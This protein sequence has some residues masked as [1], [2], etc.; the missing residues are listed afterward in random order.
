MSAPRSTKKG[1][2]ATLERPT[3]PASTDTP[4]PAP[5]PAVTGYD[6]ELKFLATRF[7]QGGRLNYSLVLSPLEIISL[8]P[9]PDPDTP[10]E[11]NR[12]IRPQHAAG[13]A[14]YVR[15][16]PA[17]ISPAVLLRAPSM[18]NF[19]AM[20]EVTGREFGTI[21]FPRLSLMDIRIVDGQH[22]ILGFHLTN[23]QI[24]I[25]MDKARSALAS[26][27]RVDPR[28][29]AVGVAQDRIAELDRQRKRLSDEAITVQ[30]MVEENAT[31]YKQ[32][33]YDIAANQVG[34]TASVNARFDSTKVVN[35]ALEQVLEHP[36]LHNRTDPERDR[37][38]RGSPY[39]MG[40]KHVA[41][42]VRSVQVGLDGRVSRR[43]DME[44]KEQDVAA[45]AARFLDLTVDAFP[46]LQAIVA[47]QIMPDDLRKTSLLGS[48]LMMR[49]LAGV[50]FELTTNHAFSDAMVKD[51]FA[52]LA[53]H[54]VG[55]VYPQSVWMTE[56]NNGAFSEG[57]MA[58][59][60]R[61]QDLKTV[62]NALVAAAVEKPAWLDKAPAPRPAP[63][64]REEDHPEY[65][66]GYTNH[67][68]D[69][70]EKR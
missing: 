68:A 37:V 19:E 21:A 46:P 58:P 69:L 60:G 55:P 3:K 32:A 20:T 17:W 33:F 24:A 11:G 70:P 49:I 35:R 53:P 15:E 51:F 41:E 47:G 31:A 64:L 38:G 66:I 1:S 52:T 54:M 22:R 12:R 39:L 56:V 8:I 45:R 5:M 67:G 27:R 4:A 62:K 34:I 23:E 28:G 30:I 36:L 25:E 57:A 42:M 29:G 65:G 7:K 40:A 26:A 48:V 44:W 18:F 14:R 63:E 61:R 43:Q 59:N 6:T 10:T 50:Y 9:K 13:F 2:V 16:R